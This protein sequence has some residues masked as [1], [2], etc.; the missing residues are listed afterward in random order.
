M[1]H[2][3]NLRVEKFRL[4]SGPTASLES[5][6][7]NGMFF[8]SRRFVTLRCMVSDGGGWDHVSVSLADRCPKHEEM[9]FVRELFFHD[10][11]CVVLYS[12]PRSN[13]INVHPYCLHMWRQHDVVVP[14]PPE[15]MVG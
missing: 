2:T 11:E 3:P 10:D 14:L 9:E 6:G 12:V 5:D 13:H 1:R 7:N 4:T 15:W 8:V